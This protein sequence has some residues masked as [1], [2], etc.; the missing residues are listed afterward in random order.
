[1]KKIVIFFYMLIFGITYCFSQDIITKINGEDIQAVVIN[2]DDT[3]VRYKKFDYFDGPTYTIPT[4]DIIMIR[5]NDGRKDIFLQQAQTNSTFDPYNAPYTT[6]QEG[7]RPNML[8]R[9]YKKLYNVNYYTR[10]YSD[11]HNPLI[12]GICSSVV[13]GL[14]QM[15]CG[16]LGRGSAYFGGSLGCFALSYTGFIFMFNGIFSYSTSLYNSGIIMLFSGIAGMIT[17]KIFD[18]VDAVNVAKI[19]NMYIRDIR[20]MSAFNIKLQ[21]YIDCIAI[22]NNFM[23]PAG[24]S[25]LVSF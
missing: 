12:I 1:M 19:K 24:L 13:P 8:Y 10:H 20:N 5:Y 15:I 17:I 18:I 22:G 23:L 21:P 3:E 16:E 7:I 25:L 2:I 6:S 9:E 4:S 14:G 11:A